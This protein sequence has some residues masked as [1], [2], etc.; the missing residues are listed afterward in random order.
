MSSLKITV[1]VLTAGILFAPLQAL[2]YDNASIFSPGQL[3]A[4][5]VHAEKPGMILI[6]NVHVF[7]GKNEKRLMNASVLVEG[8]LIKEVSTGPVKA[9]GAT[10][11]DG[12]GQERR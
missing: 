2:A 4:E 3:G 1:V 12:G 9:D 5:T 11:I 10:V 6:T 7:D 8:K